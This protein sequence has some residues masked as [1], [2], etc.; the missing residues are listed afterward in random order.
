MGLKEQI[1][2]TDVITSES[3]TAI[4]G[5]SLFDN[6]FNEFEAFFILDTRDNFS[7]PKKGFYILAKDELN[8]D[9]SDFNNVFNT[10]ELNISHYLGLFKSITINNTIRY[11]HTF[12]IASSPRIPVNKLFFSGGSDTVRGFTEDGLAP[13][14]GTASLIYNGEVQFALTESLKVAGFFDVGFLIDNMNALS[15]SDIRESA[16]FGLRYLTPVGPLRLDY[17]MILD[18]IPGEQRQR[19]H[20]SFGYFF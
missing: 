16:G 12:K 17:G 5:N 2:R 18:R 14:G 1:T 19:M 15:V 10:I 7:D 13:S 20:V 11:G 8:V 9:L 3:N 6:T 4:L